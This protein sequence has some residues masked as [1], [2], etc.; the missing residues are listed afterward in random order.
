MQVF[1][2]I[3][4]YFYRGGLL[5]V[6][7][8]LVSVVM[9]VLILLKLQTV[10]TVNQRDITLDEAL[11]AVRE[12]CL[13][14]SF[15]GVPLYQVVSHF[16]ASMGQVRADNL[17]LL[18]SLVDRETARLGSHINYIYALASIAP[19]LGLLGTV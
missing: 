18:N 8:I 6:P 9:W 1:F 12:R 16:I 3:F 13:Q 2:E 17:A 7:I 4:D 15:P 11:I 5:L 14:K 10:W 19:L